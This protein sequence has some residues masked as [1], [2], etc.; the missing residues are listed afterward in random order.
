M[1]HQPKTTP[2]QRAQIYRRVVAGEKRNDL[3]KEYGI[4]RQMVSIIVKKFKKAG[5]AAQA[6]EAPLGRQ[7]RDLKT[8]IP[9]KLEVLRRLVTTKSP[10]ELGLRRFAY[11]NFYGVRLAME[12]WLH[13]KL[14]QFE[15]EQLLRD[16]GLPVYHVPRTSPNRAD[17]IFDQ[18]FYDYIN[19]DIGRQ[20][21][22]RSKL[23]EE[24]EKREL[25]KRIAEG[26]T[27]RKRGRPRKEVS[28]ASHQGAANL[29]PPRVAKAEAPPAPE[30]PPG[31]KAAADSWDL[32]SLEEME[33]RLE[34][35]ARQLDGGKVK[36]VLDHYSPPPKKR[37]SNFTPPKKKR[38]K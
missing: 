18:D 8:L 33:R 19:S 24:R 25:E 35:A 34:E 28:E 15:A 12:Q 4:T 2:E 29:V 27:K 6:G 30:K 11:W 1:N 21:R 37:G 13:F 22:E 20:V 31:Q 17:D 16:W 36:A 3:V 26:W 32:P 10:V 14:M 23:A 9:K 38:R 7:R 5:E